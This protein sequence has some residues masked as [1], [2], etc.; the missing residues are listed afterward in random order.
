[1]LKY[2]IA[3][4]YIKLLT[5]EQVKYV[6]QIVIWFNSSVVFWIC[7]H[8]TSTK[9]V[10]C[11]SGCNRLLQPLLCPH[12]ITVILSYRYLKS[13]HSWNGNWIWRKIQSKLRVSFMKYKTKSWGTWDQLGYSLFSLIMHWSKNKPQH[14]IKK[15]MHPNLPVLMSLFQ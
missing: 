3:K 6:T 1:M 9:S 13:L 12:V 10:V 8:V 4:W 11:P 5:E 14:N 2:D 7:E 15:C